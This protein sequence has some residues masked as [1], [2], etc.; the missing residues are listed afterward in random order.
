MSVTGTLEGSDQGLLERIVGCLRRERVPYALIGAWALT[1][2]GRSRATADVD[3]LVLVGED[4]LSRLGDRFV[5]VYN[6][7]STG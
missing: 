4:K 3:F 2:W 7:S 1:A 5:R 6:G